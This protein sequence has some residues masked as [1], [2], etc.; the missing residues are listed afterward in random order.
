MKSI[1]HIFTC[2]ALSA[3]RE[4]PLRFILLLLFLHNLDLYLNI[5]LNESCLLYFKVLSKKYLIHF[6]NIFNYLKQYILSN[7]SLLFLFF[8]KSFFC[9]TF[10]FVFF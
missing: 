3:V 7:V 5:F 4:S 10:H 6:L 2:S 9:F 1:N 8:S